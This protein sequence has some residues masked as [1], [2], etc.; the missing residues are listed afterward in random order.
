MDRQGATTESYNPVDESLIERVQ[1]ANGE[2]YE[3]VVRAA[4]AVFSVWSDL[5]APK[6][7]EIVR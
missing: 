7:G 4:Q 2:D 3:E 6:R 1:H 5:P